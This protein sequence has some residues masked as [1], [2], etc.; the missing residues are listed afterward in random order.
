MGDF[1][2]YMSRGLENS[3]AVIEAQRQALLDRLKVV[4]AKIDEMS[5]WLKQ[6]KISHHRVESVGLKTEFLY[7][8]INKEKMLATQIDTAIKRS[9]DASKLQVQKDQLETDRRA[10]AALQKLVESD[11]VFPQIEQIVNQAVKLHNTNSARK[12]LANTGMSANVLPAVEKVVA[13]LEKEID[14]YYQQFTALKL[15]LDQLQQS[16]DGLRNKHRGG[17]QFN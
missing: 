2:F 10:F 16:W 8:L 11:K 12:V 6:R 15:Q 4:S 5:L 13:A 1:W 9:Q 3:P 17:V 7:L 14:N